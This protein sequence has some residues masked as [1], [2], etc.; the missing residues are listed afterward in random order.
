MR[1]PRTRGRSIIGGLTR[2][3][4]VIAAGATI[5]IGLLPM[6]TGAMLDWSMNAA[7]SL[8]LGA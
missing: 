6:V 1:R 2:V 8:L 3:G 7:R 5:A 4:L